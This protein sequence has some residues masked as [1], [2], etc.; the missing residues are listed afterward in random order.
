MK[1]SLTAFLFLTLLCAPLPALFPGA[2]R[3]DA[4]QARLVCLNIG[5]ADCMLLLLPDGAFLID[6]GYAQTYPALETALKQYGVSHLNGVFL[7]HCHKDHAGGLYALAQSETAVDAWYAARIYF[8]VDGDQHPAQAAA[9][10]RGQEVVWLDA[11]DTI[12]AGKNGAFTVLGPRTVNED[13]ENNNSLVLRFSSPAGSI[14]FAGDMK[15]DEEYDLLAENA[16]SPCA[17]LKAG[18]HGDS[19][20]TTDAMLQKVRPQAAVIL[21][22]TVEEMDTPDP[23]TL[24][25]LAAV[26]SAVYVSQDAEDALLFTLENGTV[27]SVENVAWAGVPPRAQG[28][29]LVLDTAD[30]RLTIQNSGSEA[31]SLAGCLLYSLKGDETLRLPDQTLLPGQ[32]LIIGTRTTQGDMDLKWDDKRV[33]NQKKR[34]VAILYDPY[35]RALARTDNGLP[36]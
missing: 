32:A 33:W 13:N 2:S 5:K 27:A 22:S 7:T 35:G 12:P 1:R 4:E 23:S 8:D 26:G 11:G 30:D 25:R 24:R 18:H 14:L 36:E 21:T 9:A 29:S 28:L 15:E 10:L 31:V 3:A 20:A 17:L 34:D 6:A 16:F 19:G